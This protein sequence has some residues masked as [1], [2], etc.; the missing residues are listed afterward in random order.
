M[1]GRLVLVG[2]NPIPVEVVVD[3][4]TQVGGDQTA[5]ERLTIMRARSIVGTWQQYAEWKAE[6]EALSNQ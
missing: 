5:G 2:G 3:V 4:G 1:F 6:A